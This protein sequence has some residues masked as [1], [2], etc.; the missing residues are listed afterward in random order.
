MSLLPCWLQPVTACCQAMSCSCSLQLLLYA[1]TNPG[2]R[3]ITNPRAHATTDPGAHATTN[4]EAHSVS[5]VYNPKTVQSSRFER[6]SPALG[7]HFPASR[8]DLDGDAICPT[9]EENQYYRYR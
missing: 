2:A 8:T 9:F 7:D 3:A 5:C 1:T 6:D 4:P